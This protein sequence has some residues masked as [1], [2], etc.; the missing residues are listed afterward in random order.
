MEVAMSRNLS[1]HAQ[2]ALL[3]AAAAGA[4]LMFPGVVRAATINVN[5]S[6]GVF[7]NGNCSLREAI[8]AARTNLA[9]DL[10]TAGSAA[11]DTIALPATVITITVSD[12]DDLNLSGDYDI[13]G[14]GGPLIISGAGTTVT[15]IDGG[16]LNRA[17]DILSD[18]DVTIRDLTIRN[19][20]TPSGEDGGA[21]RN[22]G[23]LT[24]SNLYL[25]D[26]QTFGGTDADGGAVDHNN[27][28]ADASL[29]VTDSVLANN[30]SSDDGGAI[31]SE[32]NLKVFNSVIIGNSASD[33]GGGIRHMLDARIENTVIRSN[34][35][36]W[37]GGGVYVNY[38]SVSKLAGNLLLRNAR[39]EGNTASSSSAGDGG[40][41]YIDGSSTASRNPVVRIFYSDIVS[42]VATSP[43]V[44]GDQ[45][46]GGISGGG[47]GE[48]VIIIG[49]KISY[50][51][52][53]DDGGGIYI[54]NDTATANA[55]DFEW[56]YITDT[57]ISSNSAGDAGGGIRYDGNNGYFDHITVESNWMVQRS[58][59]QIY[60]GDGGGMALQG[61]VTITNNTLIRNNM[62]LDDGGGLTVEEGAFSPVVLIYDSS[63]VGNACS[64]V[65]DPGDA[66]GG[67]LRVYRGAT[68][69][70]YNTVVS[71]N[72]AE[73]KGGG[74]RNQG[75]LLLR[76]SNVY[77]NRV[78]G[79]QTSTGGGI[80]S[81]EGDA[82]I[83]RSTIAYNSSVSGGAVAVTWTGTASIADVTILGNQAAERGGALYAA[84]GT[85]MV[86]ATQI[87]GNTAAQ[88]G[89]GA[90]FEGGSDLTFD[91]VSVYGNH[92]TGF[93]GGLAYGGAQSAALMRSTIEQNTAAGGAGI[94]A[95]TGAAALVG[96]VTLTGNQ[97]QVNGGGVATV[98]GQLVVRNATIVANTASGAGGGVY[99][100]GGTLQLVNAIVSSNTD[101]GS[102]PDCGGTGISSG[103]GLLIKDTS[104]CTI[105]L[106]TGDVTGQDP[107]L[108]PI[109]GYGTETRHYPLS[110]SSPAIELG[111][112]GACDTED[113][114]GI[115]RPIGASCDAGSVEFRGAELVLTANASA[116]SVTWA[117]TVQFTASVKNQGPH[118]S[119]GPTVTIA[120]P[121]EL[122]FL[123]SND[124]GCVHD[125]ATSGGTVTCTF[126]DLVSGAA[127]PSATVTAEVRKGG[128]VS[129]SVV[130][131]AQ[132]LD[133]TRTDS[134]KT[135]NLSL[136]KMAELAV[137]VSAPTEILLGDDE[138]FALRLTNDGPNDGTGVKIR[139]APDAASVGLFEF[140][141]TQSSA[142]LCT[143]DGNDVLCTADSL[144]AG[145]AEDLVLTYRAQ[146]TG[147]SIF[148]VSITA[149]EAD[150]IR[151]NNAVTIAV[152]VEAKSGVLTVGTDDAFQAHDAEVEFDAADIPMLAFSLSGDNAAGL[153]V[154]GFTLRAS[155]TG[156]DAAGIKAVKIYLD[157]NANGRVDDDETV[158][159][160]GQYAEDDGT[161]ELT[162]AEP[163]TI[164][165]G[166]SVALLVAYDLLG[167]PDSVAGLRV[168]PLV[169]PAAGT[170]WRL[171]AHG[172]VGASLSVLVA[173]LLTMVG[174]A[175]LIRKSG[176]G[177]AVPLAAMLLL[178]VA[179]ETVRPFEIELP[180]GAT[181]TVEL[182]DID[183]A[184]ADGQTVVDLAG[185]PVQGATI[186][187]K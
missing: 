80:L 87:T 30:Y 44:D 153:Q 156:D 107:F 85:L 177:L 94:A 29:L 100:Q 145:A 73:S 154:R 150:A 6:D 123:G 129:V 152:D 98:G 50:N 124:A 147:T 40:G 162:L 146:L 54:E 171:P 137:V 45:D 97:A 28:F 36:G 46:G 179:C 149:N 167:A 39:I 158:L 12:F 41:I 22:K 89:G 74:I 135:F 23:R 185:L 121:N 143:K 138:T 108:L 19:G 187:I 93:G 175:V 186:T 59:P 126:A 61:N 82:T 141:G 55:D 81:Q 63:I 13:F 105:S 114:R 21:I 102:A 144:A 155:G 115:G 3:A 38:D 4:I 60:E 16:N 151:A 68:V 164:A 58:D 178:G 119:T 64:G 101:G 174:V 103:G 9:V 112:N 65:N 5:A 122:V 69:R 169:P 165:A 11:T 10:C 159:V 72:T 160:F 76:D 136:E 166:D 176:A 33:E 52:A 27:A 32:Q 84:G 173:W 118:P 132:T 83:E 170:D 104:G 17:F 34:T 56:L 131:D 110:F 86:A 96:T 14:S 47:D 2:R 140:V 48:T 128:T 88:F 66:G 31:E 134:E 62:C 161:L 24:L 90:F 148:A 95:V 157:A 120:L 117:G 78:T 79:T 127:S 49:S 184:G 92:A 26:N 75:T 7:A 125:G 1:C 91:G 20:R 130:A 106:A 70:L 43:G 35:S 133:P 71:S 18:E 15:V 180:P 172:H 111:V 182:T 42:N 8:D 57:T 183:A 139:L 99:G 168:A 25:H 37:D 181:F 51:Q 109:G 113:Q 163:M 116:N 67:G 77:R 53:L 142:F